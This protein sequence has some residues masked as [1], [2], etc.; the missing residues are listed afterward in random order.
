MNKYAVLQIANK[1]LLIDRIVFEEKKSVA[2][3]GR[4]DFKNKI[5][6]VHMVYS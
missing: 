1:T 2:L 6:K 4:V 3:I 5:P